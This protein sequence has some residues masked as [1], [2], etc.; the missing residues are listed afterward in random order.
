M[1][2]GLLDS[3]THN[4]FYRTATS[5]HASQWGHIKVIAGVSKFAQDCNDW[6][7]YYTNRYA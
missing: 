7:G 5:F 6:Q 4:T 1:M 3:L 2:G